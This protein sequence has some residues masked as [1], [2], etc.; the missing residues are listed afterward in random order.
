M[1]ITLAFTATAT[2][3]LFFNGWVLLRAIRQRRQYLRGGD[4]GRLGQIAN[5]FVQVWVAIF[6][7]D[8]MMVLAGI[9]ILVGFRPFGY[10]LAL[11]P[12]VSAIVGIFALRGFD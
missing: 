9:G 1:P 11:V 8:L 3:A 6:A 5:A 4:N 10:L 12:L 7:S 2:V